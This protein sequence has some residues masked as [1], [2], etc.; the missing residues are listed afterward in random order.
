VFS[1]IFLLYFVGFIFLLFCLDFVGFSLHL[2]LWLIFVVETSVPLWFFV[3]FALQLSFYSG[4]C[5]TRIGLFTKFLY[6]LHHLV[7]PW[8]RP[9]LLKVFLELL[10]ITIACCSV[11]FT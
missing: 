5:S 3:V 11:F 6:N 2:V 8:N 1:C 10:V 7:W 4:G 9:D